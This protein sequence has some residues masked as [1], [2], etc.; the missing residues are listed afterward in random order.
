[1]PH[2]AIINDDTAFLQLMY[3]LL[4]MQGYDVVLHREG[5]HAH[6]QVKEEKPDLIVLDIR[7]ERPDSGWLV[8]DLLR[9]DPQTSDIPVI[10]CSADAIELREKQDLLRQQ[11][12]E[13]L[14][15]P[16]DLN[17]LLAIINRKIGPP[18][19]PASE[20]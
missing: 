17:D 5:S 20:Q 6:R 14:E 8:L 13:V 1:M 12:Y 19:A 2:I 7:M 3:D 15:K 9:L 18:R 11:G 16:F 10:V 4:D